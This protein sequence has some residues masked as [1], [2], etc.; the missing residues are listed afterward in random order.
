MAR[1]SNMQVINW[2]IAKE[3]LKRREQALFHLPEWITIKDICSRYNTSRSTL[4]RLRK[5]G[6]F[7]LPSTFMGEGVLRWDAAEID[8]LMRESKGQSNG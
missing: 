4:S 8:K 6:K 7:P 2:D 3:K 1:A 5:K